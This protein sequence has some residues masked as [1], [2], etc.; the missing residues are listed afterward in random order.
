[1]DKRLVSRARGLPLPL[2]TELP[3]RVGFSEIR[4]PVYGILENSLDL[5]GI[6]KSQG[7]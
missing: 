4:L 7:C 1:V 3:G 2:F 6:E 5:E